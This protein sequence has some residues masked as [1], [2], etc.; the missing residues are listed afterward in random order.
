ML[1]VTLAGFMM[2]APAQ[3]QTTD[4]VQDFYI[5]ADIPQAS[6]VSFVVSDV[7]PTNNKFYDHDGALSALTF[8]MSLNPSLGIYTPYRIFAIDVSTAGGAGNP[9]L[10]LLYTDTNN[11][12]ADAGGNG[13]T[14]K[15]VA[16]IQNVVGP[17]GSQTVTDVAKARL[18][19]I[20]GSYDDLLFSGGFARIIVGIATGNT[21]P[22]QGAVDPDDAEPFTNGDQPGEYRGTLQITATLP[23]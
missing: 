23:G 19:A 18:G 11:P 17:E 7:D 6:S 8:S 15:G 22:Q 20:S 9:D 5:V 16:T 13:L 2:S 14:H 12:N 1:A 3:A 21:D 10:A 4:T